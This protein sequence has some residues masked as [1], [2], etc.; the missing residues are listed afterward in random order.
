MSKKEIIRSAVFILLVLCMLLGLSLVLD[1]KT[2]CHYT[3][4]VEGYFNEE[5]ESMDIMFYG[6]SHSYCTMNPLLLW[7][8]TGLRSY[9][10]SSQSQPLEGTYQYMK[11]SFATQSPKLVVLELG[12]MSQTLDQ[13]GDGVLRDCIDPMPWTQG[14]AE[15][16]RELVPQGQRSSYYFNLAKYHGRWKEL[17]H[18][19]LDFSFING[20]AEH[21]GFYCFTPANPAVCG[22]L[23]Y[24]GVDASA[25][26]E[27]NVAQ[28]LRIRDLAQANGAEL[29][30]FL[31]PYEGAENDLGF[32]KALHLMC[33]ENNIPLIDYNLLYDELGFD[34]STD[35]YDTNHFNAY[36]AAKATGYFARWVEE[37]Y[38]LE[39]QPMELDSQWQASWAE[40]KRLIY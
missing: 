25:L 36:G 18:T 5:P 14:K 16:I 31:T 32:F 30:C 34:G 7:S 38:G 12:I 27:E 4:A 21:K 17:D 11:Q 10:L 28:L 33:E 8:E 1:R 29:V 26:P 2:A 19:T 22:Q 40:M 13:A 9:V 15:L 37:H 35:F 24:E 20:R 6:T 23:S 39:P 3:V